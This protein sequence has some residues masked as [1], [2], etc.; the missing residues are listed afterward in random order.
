MAS[1][2]DA[3][4]EDRGLG[5]RMVTTSFS[6][7]STKKTQLSRRAWKKKRRTGKLLTMN[8]LGSRSER[9]YVKLIPK[10]KGQTGS[11]SR[12]LNPLDSKE[13]HQITPIVNIPSIMKSGI[14]SKRE[15]KLIR[16]LS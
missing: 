10:I 8:R 6:A 16:R 7:A 2:N 1:K 14:L 9:L 4:G 12:G 5:D 3:E 15:I 11:W 13:L